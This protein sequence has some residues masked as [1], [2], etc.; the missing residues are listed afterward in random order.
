M[1][2]CAL[3]DDGALAAVGLWAGAR[4]GGAMMAVAVAAAAVAVGPDWFWNAPDE[5][6]SVDSGS[7]VEI[8]EARFLRFP[9]RI[10][11]AVILP[12]SVLA[13]LGLPFVPVWVGAA[14]IAGLVVAEVAVTVRLPMRQME[15]SAAVPWPTGLSRVRSSTLWV[16][17]RRSAVRPTRAQRDPVP[18]PNPTRPIGDDCVSVGPDANLRVGLSAWVAN[19]LYEG[20]VPAVF[21]A[22]ASCDIPYRRS[23][24][25]IVEA[26]ALRFRSALGINKASRKNAK[27]MGSP[28]TP[29]PK[30]RRPGPQ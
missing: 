17:E 11:W 7:P 4:F 23:L 26:D 15:R 5:A 30:T 25:L 14:W 1:G 22:S 19:R 18:V 6:Y 27:A 28:C 12:L 16:K 24:R 13:A 29:F 21:R 3:G 10:M 20:D 2:P 9:G 8:P